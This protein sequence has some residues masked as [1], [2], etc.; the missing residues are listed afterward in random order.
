MQKSK[1]DLR[2]GD[3][4]QHDEKAEFSIEFLAKL[5]ANRDKD[6]MV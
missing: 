5:A 2:R 4:I 3:R 1:K 6:S